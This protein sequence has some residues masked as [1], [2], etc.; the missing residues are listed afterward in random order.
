MKELIIKP[1]L[2]A[3]LGSV[4]F[5]DAVDVGTKIVAASASVL[6]SWYAIKSYKARH[7]LD[8]EHLKNLKD[9]EKH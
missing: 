8:K 2:A 7:A 1:L 9:N 5:L 6:V 3:A 4:T